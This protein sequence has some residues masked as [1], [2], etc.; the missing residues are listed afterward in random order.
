MWTHIHKNAVIGGIAQDT[1]KEVMFIIGLIVYGYEQ[2]HI[3]RRCNSC[4]T[5][6][7]STTINL[8]VI[9]S[10]LGRR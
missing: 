9:M 7:R 5:Y 8:C 6:Q 10:G 4:K 1:K 3:Q 2:L